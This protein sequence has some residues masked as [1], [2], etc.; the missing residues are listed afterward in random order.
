[1]PEP[2]ELF[3]DAARHVT[4]AVQGIWQRHREAGR[5]AGV[6]LADQR[7]RLEL[8]IEAALG[9]PWPIRSAQS[10]APVPFVRR[11]LRP[12]RAT[13]A[14][15]AVL[16]GNDGTAVY[17]P[18]EL[19]PPPGDASPDDY[20]LLAL[21]QALRCERGSAA[22]L[23][24]DSALA[25]DLYILAECS[26]SEAELRRIM[27]GWGPALD[28][29]KGRLARSGRAAAGG[30]SAELIRRYAGYLAGEPAAVPAFPAPADSLAWARREAALLAERFPRER[31]RPCLADPWIGRLFPPE[32]G[33]SD[34]GRW[35]SRG[36]ESEVP[37][38]RRQA[39]LSR[40][41][42]AREALEDEDDRSPGPWMV[43]ASEPMEHA[44]DPF[45]IDR[46]VDQ[47]S[48]GDLPG[49]ADSLSE[50]EE[51]RLVRT[52]GSARETLYGSDP[53]PAGSDQLAPLEESAGFIYP[54][55]DFSRG[56]YLDKAVRV[57]GRKVPEG[58]SAWVEETLSRHAGLLAEIRRRL[59]A[60][61]PERQVLRRQPD[62]EDIDCD[63]L[64]AE[65]SERRAGVSPP[66]AVYINRRPAPRQLALLLLV[67]ASGSTDAWV[68]DGARIIDV[69]KEAALV[70]ASALEAARIRFAVYAFSG[71]G[72]AGVEVGEIKAFASP[73]NSACQRRLAGLEPDRYTRLGA[74]VRH[75][76]SL[77]SRQPADRRLLLLFSDGRPNDCDRYAGR[78]G[79][80]DARQALVEARLQQLVPYCFTVD[81]EGGNYLP[82]LFG[83]GRFTIVQRAQQLPLSFVAWLRRA[84][85]E[86]G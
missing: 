71:E 64:V 79:L 76:A 55:W 48:E 53:P 62:G 14:P 1:M 38:E 82:T 78:H 37:G 69:E 13:A 63:A 11:L 31:H 60:L 3:I 49:T 73:W 75:A 8:L 58:P 33:A 42:R 67:D 57:H 65:R 80:E 16:P 54:E 9:R 39:A 70:A 2:E 24:R 72:P 34:G 86:C 5:T 30:A 10:A 51:A 25:A 66:G 56:V 28:G 59:G 32:A 41:P 6:L 40:R 61:R 52:P 12:E 81:R 50:M 45:G 4:A 17:L 27:P 20:A 19:P 46:P 74:A 7:R 47:D 36:Q 18:P 85:R 29:F 21:H 77:L 44:E 68:A 22:S 35:Q 84:A 26:A 23:P 43:Q 15:E 83:A